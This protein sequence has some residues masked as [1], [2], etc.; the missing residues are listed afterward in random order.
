MAQDVA[1]DAQGAARDGSV[2]VFVVA[3]V[4]FVPP[5]TQHVNDVAKD[6]TQT[7]RRAY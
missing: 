4:I 2:K 3:R 1:Q 5:P 6:V 7:W